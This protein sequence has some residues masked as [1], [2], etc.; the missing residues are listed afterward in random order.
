M[1]DLDWTINGPGPGLYN[2]LTRFAF[3]RD[4]PR[5]FYFGPFTLV[6]GLRTS[7]IRLDLGFG[8]GFVNNLFCFSLDKFNTAASILEETTDWFT[9]EKITLKR[10]YIASLLDQISWG[11]ETRGHR[12]LPSLSSEPLVGQSVKLMRDHVDRMKRIWASLD[13][14]MKPVIDWLCNPFHVLDSSN[15]RDMEQINKLNQKVAE[16]SMP[17]NR[18][19]LLALSED[20]ALPT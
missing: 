10:K 18:R 15:E 2:N 14:K 13:L 16:R 3:D 12:K 5:N 9:H 11:S 8:L 17:E 7:S 20:I 1:N 19:S 4:K 6:Y